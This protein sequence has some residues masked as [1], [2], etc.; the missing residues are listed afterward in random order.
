M[1]MDI[2]TPS[3]E[4]PLEFTGERYTSATSGEIKHEHY[5]RYFFSLQFCSKK[6]VLDIA[7]GEGYG[8]ALL[9]IVAQEVFGV[10]I[11]PAAVSHASRNY[12]S[13]RVSF[14]I[15]DCIAIPLSDASVDVVVSFETLEH[16]ADQKKFFCEIKRVL[17]P[18]GM[19][20]ISTPNVEVY[21]DVAT[22]PNPFH[23]KELD[24]TEF[25]AILS[26]NFATYRLF[27]QRSV[28]GSAITPDLPDLTEVDRQQTF[29]AVD[30]RVYSVQSGL[31]AP[32]YLIAVASDA[33]LPEIHHGLLDDRPFL[34]NLYKLLQERAIAI[35]DFEHQLRVAETSRDGL[36][37]QL[38]YRESELTEVHSQTSKLQGELRSRDED[39]AQLRRELRSRDEGQ[40]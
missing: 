28:I 9:G 23:V 22:K 34:L 5:H 18:D 27:G 19:L 21:K 36:Q 17:R 24:A 12:R 3:P 1:V 4:E 13:A 33:P 6:V 32:T 2:V 15:G 35:L 20:V 29:R 11:A 37:Q 39:L 14:T 7:S 8:S 38:R 40:R 31:G 26:E 30:N 10:E 16:L 25:R